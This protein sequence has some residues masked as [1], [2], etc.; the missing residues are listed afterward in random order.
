LEGDPEPE[1]SKPFKT[2]MEFREEKGGKG[3]KREG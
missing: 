1:L 2:I 3:E